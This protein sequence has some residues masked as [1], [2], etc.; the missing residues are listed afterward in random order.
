MKKEKKNGKVPAPAPTPA[1]APAP[2]PA[3]AETKTSGSGCD[4]I[5][6]DGWCQDEEGTWIPCHAGAGSITGIGFPD[7]MDIVW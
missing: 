3:S 2:A 1:S 4:A 6:D 5:C 7:E